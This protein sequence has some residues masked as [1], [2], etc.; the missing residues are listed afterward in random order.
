MTPL[1]KADN[2]GKDYG[3]GHGV[4]GLSFE[5]RQGEILG[6]LGVNGAGKSTTMDMLSGN[7][8]PTRGRIH[9]NGIDL[10]ENPKKAKRALGYLPEQPPLARSLYP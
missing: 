10:A 5:L 8:V 2:L 9:I 3:R 4:S 7:L 1:V 6:L